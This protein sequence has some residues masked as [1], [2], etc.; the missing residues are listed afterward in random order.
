MRRKGFSN[1]IRKVEG[2]PV[3]EPCVPLHPIH[4]GI[5]SSYPWRKI[6][7]E[8]IEPGRLEWTEFSFNFMRT[9]QGETFW[10]EI[11]AGRGDQ[12]LACEILRSWREQLNATLGVQ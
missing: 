8:P 11:C 4:E 9:P 5:I 7:T 3:V 12:Q 6:L 1:F 2:L 10:W